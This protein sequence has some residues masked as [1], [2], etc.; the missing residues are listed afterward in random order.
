[1]RWLI[2]PQAFTNPK[3]YH[4]N[5]KIALQDQGHQ[6][7]LWNDECWDRGLPDFHEEKVLFHGSLGNAARI[8]RECPTWTP[9][10]YCNVT[11]LAFSHWASAV[12]DNLLNLNHRILPANELV[13]NPQ[14]TLKA[15]GSP[16]RVFVRPDSPLKEF[17]GRLLPADG[18]TLAALDHGFYFEDETLPVMVSPAQNIGKEWRFVV[19]NQE[20]VTGSAYNPATHE[21]IPDGFNG[22]ALKFAVQ[23][24]QEIESPE[25]VYVMDVC[26]TQ[27]GFKVIEFNPF[28]GASL[29]GCDLLP[30]VKAVGEFLG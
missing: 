15:L 21:R 26:I 25:P 14:V 30:L 23:V 22:A 8:T 11:T 12:G 2:E 20:V 1:M 5:F 27:G 17:S 4:E 29:Y 6:Y 28:S 10:A 16:D 13:A 24:A 3:V 19:V 18:L 7:A 9:G